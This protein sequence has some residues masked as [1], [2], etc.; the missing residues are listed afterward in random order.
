MNKE[1]LQAL[2][3]VLREVPDANF[4]LET[5][6][7]TPGS[8]ENA[9]DVQ[10][11]SHNCGTTACAIGWA[12]AMPE[13]QAQGLRW[14]GV[15]PALV[16]EGSLDTGWDAVK[17]FFGISYHASQRLFNQDGYDIDVHVTPNDVAD[18]IEDF[19]KEQP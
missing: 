12:C 19:V 17:V 8:G 16:G 18:S 15:Q 13:F 1:R 10:V 3:N 6:R 5:W 4:D 9:T 11:L 7:Y 14:E 2:A